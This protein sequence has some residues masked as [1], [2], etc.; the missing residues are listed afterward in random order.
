MRP[1]QERP[2]SNAT[3]PL[4]GSIFCRSE[5]E[6][7]MAIEF[8]RC[9]RE[10]L[11]LACFLVQFE[12]LEQLEAIHGRES[13]DEVRRRVSNLL[14]RSSRAGDLLGYPEGE[15]LC[16]LLPHSEREA[17]EGM[18]RRIRAQVGQWDFSN[19]EVSVRVL[20]RVGIASNVDASVDSLQSL[21]AAAYDALLAQSTPGNPF[22]QGAAAGA[23]AEVADRTEPARARS[24]RGRANRAPQLSPVA[25]DDKKGAVL[26]SIF[27]SNLALQTALSRGRAG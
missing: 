5:V 21:R 8:A 20:V 27:E 26:L 9:E 22:A 17:A 23:G 6:G 10:E 2:D 15:L 18:A 4:G 12:G 7:L 16:M 1:F 24:R 13:G 3:A 19:G 14:E 11:P 25:P